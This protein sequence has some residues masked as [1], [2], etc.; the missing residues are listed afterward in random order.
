LTLH[1]PTNVDNR[2]AFQEILDG[3]QELASTCPVVFPAH[4]RTLKRIHEQ[5][6]HG[7]LIPTRPPRTGADSSAGIRIIQPLG[8]LDFLCL[9]KNAALVITDSGGIQEETTCLGTPCVTVRENT[10]R[11][12]TL[13]TGTNVLAGVTSGGIRRAIRCQLESPR[14]GSIPQNW[15]GNAALRITKVLLHAEENWVEGHQDRSDDF[16]FAPAVVSEY[17][18]GNR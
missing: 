16:L 14:R 10:E 17:R 7:C 9:M 6:L 4:P 13:T 5:N 15:D 8:Y 2:E 12:V 1:R 3:L 11:P 18:G